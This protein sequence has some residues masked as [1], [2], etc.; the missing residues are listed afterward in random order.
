MPVALQD[1]NEEAADSAVADA[2]GVRRPVIDV[3]AV[4]EVILELALA[5]LVRAL[6]IELAQHAHRAG[7]GLPRVRSPLPLSASRLMDF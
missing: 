1:M 5:D 7:V 3:L 6:A 4:Q 2:H